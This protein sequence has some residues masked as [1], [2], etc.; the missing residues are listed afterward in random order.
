MLRRHLRTLKRPRR[1]RAHG[2]TTTVMIRSF[3]AMVLRGAAGASALPCVRA[4]WG[5]QRKLQRP[6]RQTC[7]RRRQQQG[8]L[9]ARRWRSSIARRLIPGMRRRPLISPQALLQQPLDTLHRLA[10]MILRLGSPGPALRHLLRRPLLPGLWSLWHAGITWTT[11]GMHPCLQMRILPCPQ[12]PH[13]QRTVL[14][15]LRQLVRQWSPHR[16]P[17]LVKVHASAPWMLCKRPFRKS[18]PLMRLILG[19]ASETMMTCSCLSRPPIRGMSVAAVPLATV[20]DL[21]QQEKASQPAPR[22]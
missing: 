18:C 1:K 4:H 15:R 13:L 22:W 7:H 16:R 14:R 17:R 5:I 19:V 2:M 9:G 20:P 10:G 11:P 12:P 21:A 6:W 8:V 3:L